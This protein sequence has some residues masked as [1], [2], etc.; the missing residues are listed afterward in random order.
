MKVFLTGATGLVGAQTALALLRAG[1]DLRLLVR[2][3]QLAYD[4]FADRGYRLDDFV[5]AD[6]RDNKA[7]ARAL[8][9]CDAVIHTAAMV[10]LDPRKAEEVYQ[11]NI[12]SI[13]AVIGSAIK[14]GID[15]I[16]YVSSIGAL[17]NP[18][19]DNINE[20][21][22]LGVPRDAYMR[23]KR[24][25]EVYVRQL[26]ERGAGI[27]I[28]YPSGVFAPDDPKLSE[29][30]ASLVTLL[31]VIPVTSSG[32]QFVDARD[33]A[34]AHVRLLTHTK[35][36]SHRYLVGGHFMPWQDFHR[37]LQQVTG[38]KIISLPVP[39]VILRALG[40]VMEVVKRIYPVNIP[41][42]AESMS[43]VTQLPRADS[44]KI[45]SELSVT[46]RPPQ[47]TFSD[48]VRWLAD[49]QYIH[50]KLAGRL[51]GGQERET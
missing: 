1:H 29:S 12:A 35:G 30:T 46:F 36:E 9:G 16:I 20:E 8:Q 34:E 5:V 27:K 17:F 51:A 37:L 2:N 38:R 14:Q 26:Q 40:N 7:I 6:M 32:M 24:D 11:C 25:C 49:N 19:A 41:V 50:G 15:N 4:Y 13:D 18:K 45:I 39:G 10:S 33:L 28:T 31:K 3:R 23:S 48:T 22:P 21:S 47:D 43:V 42:S 44:G